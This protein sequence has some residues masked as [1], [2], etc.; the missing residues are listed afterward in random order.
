[1]STRRVGNRLLQP[2]GVGEVKAR[3]RSSRLDSAAIDM[4]LF[5]LEMLR[6]VGKG[7]TISSRVVE[8]ICD[9]SLAAPTVPPHRT[10]PAE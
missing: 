9:P 4:M 7:F 3:R 10:G 2:R 5:M 1:M 8:R 6:R